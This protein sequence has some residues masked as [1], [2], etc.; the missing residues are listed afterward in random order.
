MPSSLKVHH[1]EKKYIFKKALKNLLPHD[2]M[3]RKKQGFS[4][5]I[6]SWFQSSLKEYSEDLLLGEKAFPVGLFRKEGVRNLLKKH[7]KTHSEGRRIW[8]LV[9]LKLWMDQFF[10]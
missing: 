7:Q 10:K 4:I 8:A 9:T 2:L 6:E 1:G 5:P 3:Y